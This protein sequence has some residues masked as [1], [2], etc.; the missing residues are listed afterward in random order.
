MLSLLRS[1]RQLA[2]RGAADVPFLLRALSTQAD[3]FLSTIPT[4]SFGMFPEQPQLTTPQTQV[5]FTPLS[6]LLGFH[7]LLP[8]TAQALAQLAVAAPQPMALPDFGTDI[9]MIGK[10]G[11]K[12]TNY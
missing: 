10:G 8:E 11:N 3:S 1:T 4:Y 5:Q 2:N 7:A 12:I 6:S 9:E